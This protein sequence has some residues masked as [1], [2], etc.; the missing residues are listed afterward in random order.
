MNSLPRSGGVRRERRPDRHATVACWHPSEFGHQTGGWLIHLGAVRCDIHVD[1]PAEHTVAC[2]LRHHLPHRLRITGDHARTRAVADSDIDPVF[3]TGKA[4]YRLAHGE[5]DDG[6]SALAARRLHE[7]AAAAHYFHGAIDTD[8]AGDGGRRHFS[9]AVP[10]HRGGNNS[11]FAQE[12]RIAN[13]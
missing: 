2:E 11:E 8:H 4:F 1:G 12:S 9:H 10:D 6:H 3:P 13:R 5:F 7:R